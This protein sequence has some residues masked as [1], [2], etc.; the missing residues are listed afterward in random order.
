MRYFYLGAFLVLVLGLQAQVNKVLMIGIDGCRPDAVMAAYTP[1]LDSLAA[2]GSHS[3]DVLNEGVTSSGPGWSSLLTSVWPEKH[4]VY[5]NSFSGSNYLN[6]PHLFKRVEEYNSALHTVSIAQWHPINDYIAVNAAD[7]MIYAADHSD[8][9]AQEAVNYIYFGEPDAMFVHF[10][11]VDHA[12][13]N[14][15]FSPDNPNYI[16]AIELVD[17]RIGDIIAA[18]K[19]RATYVSENWATIVS[20]DHGGIGTSHGGN[21]IEERNIFLIVSGDSIPNVEVLSDSVLTTIAPAVNCLND[22]VE[23]YFNGSS[24]VTTTIDPAFNFGILQDFTVECRVRTSTSGDLAIVTDKDWTSGSNPGWVFSF[25]VNGGPW[26]VNVSDGAN[27]VDIEGNEIDDN[28]WHM[29]SATFDRDGMLTIYE[30]GQQVD[31]S[32]M[33]DI[34]DVFTGFPICMGQ[35]A[36][37]GYAFSGSIA[38]VRMFN[39]IVSPAEIDSWHCTPLDNSHTNFAQLIGHWRLNEGGNNSI[40]LDESPTGANGTLSNAEWRSTQ[41][42]IFIWEKD[43]SNTPRQVDYAVSALEHLCVPMDP[44]WNLDG[45]IFGTSCNGFGTAIKLEELSTMNTYPSVNDGAFWVEFS[46]GSLWQMEI[47]NLL[48]GLVHSAQLQGKSQIDMGLAPTGPY[49]ITATNGSQVLSS[50]ILISR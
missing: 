29:L 37:N 31:A 30:D 34:G 7:L 41:D 15:G 3:Y 2:T 42:T 6:Y 14:G 12:G 20:T 28:D 44:L 26:K 46:D 50:R 11:D 8:N 43:Y 21:S 45:E 23:L 33:A 16:I 40:V 5:D 48:G 24:K 18:M 47:Y 1:I 25:N 13:H 4:G 39:G 17:Q 32:S 27:R 36:N 19:Q 9:V 10:D 49:L 22:S 35:D 38:E